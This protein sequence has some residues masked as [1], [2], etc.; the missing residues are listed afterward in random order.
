MI[1]TRTTDYA[2]IIAYQTMVKS[3]KER[4]SKT[5]LND[6]EQLT[7]DFRQLYATEAKLFLLESRSDQA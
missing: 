5:K 7:H 6:I 4:I 2:L 3:L 1:R